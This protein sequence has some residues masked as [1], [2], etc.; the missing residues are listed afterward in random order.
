[1]TRAMERTDSEIHAF[2]HCIQFNKYFRFFQQGISSPTEYQL[3]YL[4]V[5]SK[6]GVSG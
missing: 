3:G 6:L 2:S 4:V 1:M 5:D